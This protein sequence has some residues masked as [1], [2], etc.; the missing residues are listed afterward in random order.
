MESKNKAL[1]ASKFDIET[2]NLV[3][4]IEKQKKI[5]EELFRLIISLKDLSSSLE[6]LFKNLG[7]ENP[8]VCGAFDLLDTLD[9]EHLKFSSD[10]IEYR[11]ENVEF[12]IRDEISYFLNLVTPPSTNKPLILEAENDLASKKNAVR[13]REFK[14]KIKLSFAYRVL[15]CERNMLPA[16]V[17]LDV[18]PELLF[19]SIELLKKKE[20]QHQS[21]LLKQ[22][23]V[24]SKS[25]QKLSECSFMTESLLD[26]LLALNQ[27]VSENIKH[28]SLGKPV[29]DIPVDLESID[30][31]VRRLVMEKTK[32]ASRQNIIQRPVK[33]DATDHVKKED[34]GLVGRVNVWLDS[35]ISTSWKDTKNK[36]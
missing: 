25:I 36:K 21:E 6:E 14:R 34:P 12:K 19:K 16:P 33:Q 5:L 32:E 11:L 17:E 4:D 28:L 8:L 27:Q 3:K 2:I 29:S 9:D 10:K 13:I 20:N 23:K 30:F 24:F 31:D 35:P 7:A 26:E 1:D 15:L 18:A 22:F